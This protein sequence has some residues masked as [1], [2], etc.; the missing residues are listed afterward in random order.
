MRSGITLVLEVKGKPTAVDQSKWQYME[1]WIRAVNSHGGF[2]PWG[3]GVLTPGDHLAN[4]LDRH[5]YPTGNP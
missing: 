1:D 3:W 4:L 2:G 5:D